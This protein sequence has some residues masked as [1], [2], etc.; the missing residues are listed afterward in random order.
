MLVNIATVCQ[1]V[2]GLVDDDGLFRDCCV[3]QCH[4]G[5]DLR[6]TTNNATAD[7]CSVGT[8]DNSVTYKRRNVLPITASFG[9]NSDMLVYQYI[10]SND[11]LSGNKYTKRPMHKFDRRGNSGASIDTSSEPSLQCVFDPSL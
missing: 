2:R 10:I 6:P 1:V 11:G 8:D 5:S 3:N 4:P 9:A 7:K